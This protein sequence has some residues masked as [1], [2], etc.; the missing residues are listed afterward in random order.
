MTQCT[1]D[2]CYPCSWRGRLSLRCGGGRWART[3]S[4]SRESWTLFIQVR[5][6]LAAFSTPGT[7]FFVVSHPAKSVLSSVAPL[8]PPFP[9]A[10][11]GSSEFSYLSCRRSCRASPPGRCPGRAAHGA[12]LERLRAARPDSDVCGRSAAGGE[13][14]PAA[15]ASTEKTTAAETARRGRINIGRQ[16]PSGPW[17]LQRIFGKKLKRSGLKSR[18]YLDEL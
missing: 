2:E 10:P 18:M 17:V 1:M 14:K 13:A 7:L 9:D 3:P 8:F 15:D 5:I 4:S 16:G 12:L 6:S 11:A